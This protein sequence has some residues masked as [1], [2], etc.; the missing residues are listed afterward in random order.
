MSMEFTSEITQDFKFSKLSEISIFST[1]VFQT[2]SGY[3]EIQK[4]GEIIKKL[5]REIK[6]TLKLLLIN[7]LYPDSTFKYH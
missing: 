6:N 5:C 2:K 4:I 7:P 1:N 3:A